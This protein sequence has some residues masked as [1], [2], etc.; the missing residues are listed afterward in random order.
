MKLKTL[1]LKGNLIYLLVEPEDHSIIFNQDLE[2]D[3]INLKERLESF[4]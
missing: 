1:Y 2:L 4:C 3:L